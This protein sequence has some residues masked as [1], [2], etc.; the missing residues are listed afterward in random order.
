MTGIADDP[1]RE[2]SA[3]RSAIAEAVARL[4]TNGTEARPELVAL[5][6][7]ARVDGVEIFEGEIKLAGD[8]FEGLVNIH[9]ILG[10]DGEGGQAFE[11]SE[12][13][14]GRFEGTVRMEGPCITR[15]SVDTAS[16]YS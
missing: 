12:T 1:G 16:F 15:L 14:P 9:C 10:Y 4:L 5:S 2:A 7:R 6:P 13:F 11:T 3:L 8:R